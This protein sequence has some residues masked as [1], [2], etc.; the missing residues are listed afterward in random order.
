MTRKF[1]GKEQV[2]AVLYFRHSD[3]KAQI[4][5]ADP[6]IKEK[7]QPVLAQSTL[8]K[9]LRELPGSGR[10]LPRTWDAREEIGWAAIKEGGPKDWSDLLG[11]YARAEGS[12]VSIA[13]SDEEMVR[14]AQEMLAAELACA[15]AEDFE[16]CLQR[17]E[18]AYDR[19][20]SAAESLE[21]AEH[22]AAVQPAP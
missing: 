15:A 2:F 9:M 17:V 12:G 7:L 16:T 18:A 6:E 3:L 21:R 11:S 10:P 14:S 8:E 19:A 20:V 5:V 4:P 22:F 13:A 1:Q